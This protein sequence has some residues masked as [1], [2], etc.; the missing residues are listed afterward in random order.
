MVFR[1]AKAVAKATAFFIL[2]LLI[3][4]QLTL[5]T[6]KK[7]LL[8]IMQ[9]QSKNISS[10]SL[11]DPFGRN[12]RYLRL[13]VTDR[14][15]L[16]CVYC[17][18][19]SM[20]FLPKQQVLTIE[21]LHEICE[22]FIELG[23]KKIRLTGG[24]PLIRN[25]IETLFEKLGQNQQLQQL[26]LTTNG[27][28]L[29]KY[30]DAI[31]SA[32]VKRINVSLDSVEQKTFTKLGRFDHLHAVLKGLAAAKA[33]GL[34]IRINSVLL[35]GENDN[36]VLPLVDFAVENGFDIA[37][38]E[39]MPL[40][41]IDSHN[42]QD[43][44]VFNDAVAKKISS[45][46]TLNTD[47]ETDLSIKG[48][49]RYALLMGTQTRLGFIS[50]HSNNFCSTCNRVRVT[51]EGKLL[52]CLGHENS[53]DLRAILRDQNYSREHMKAHIKSALLDKP[54]EHEFNSTETHIVRFMNMT[55]G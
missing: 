26:A 20:T 30:L 37:F 7:K 28:Y 46:Y 8:L 35:A 5:F 43:T 29:E 51:V 18:S 38:I 1:Y 24:E 11:I 32:G 36:Q 9:A 53:I 27:I 21:E 49:A 55:G 50:P 13:S 10:S 47:A 52:L 34:S 14:C 22:V 39:E 44:V 42:R 54:K 3:L 48:P 16:R 17:M 19:E 12:L 31:V 15:N 45:H 23:V 33:K 6:S 4:R 25:G 41:N 40:G 2:K